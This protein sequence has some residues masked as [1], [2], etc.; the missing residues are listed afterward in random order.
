MAARIS[1]LQ[2]IIEYIGVAVKLLSIHWIGNN[3]VCLGKP[4]YGRIIPSRA[5]VVEAEADFL[6]LAG[7]ADT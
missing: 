3:G 7:V 5:I 2:W 1:I 6:A 4:P